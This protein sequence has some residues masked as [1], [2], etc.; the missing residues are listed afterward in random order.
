MV[1]LKLV[2]FK[3]DDELVQKIDSVVQQSN[4]KYRDRTHFLILAAQKLLEEEAKLKE[5]PNE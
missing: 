2:N 5:V 1:N 4:N 3:I